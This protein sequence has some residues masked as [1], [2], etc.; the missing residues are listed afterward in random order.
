MYFR[1]KTSGGRADLQIVESPRDGDSVRQQVIATLGR[2]DDFKQS[3]QLARLL[4][5]GRPVRRQCDPRRGRRVGRRDDE[6]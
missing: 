1:K 5:S 2:L 3:G 6:R 4:R